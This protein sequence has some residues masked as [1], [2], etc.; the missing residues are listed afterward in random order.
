MRSSVAEAYLPPANDS[1][2]PLSV[3]E[4]FTSP[5]WTLKTGT[6]S[7]TVAAKGG[8]VVSWTVGDALDETDGRVVELLDGYYDQAELEE[9]DGGRCAL[10]VPWSNRIHDARYTF[11][12][13]VHD[14]GPDADGTREANH[15]LGLDAEFELLAE[16]DDGPCESHLTLTGV[17]GP[18][19][20]YPWTIEVTVTYSLS[21]VDGGGSALTVELEATN[22]SAVPAPVG[23][24]WHPYI[25][26][27]EDLDALTLDLPARRR[28]VTDADHIPLDGEQ[29]F[30]SVAHGDYERLA[31]AG[32]ALDD[33]WTDLVAEDDGIIRTVLSSPTGS[34]M[35]LEQRTATETPGVG[36]VQVFTGEGLVH[37]ARESVAL[38]PCQLMTDAFNRDEGV[39]EVP[40]A[41]GATRLLDAA[42]IY[43]V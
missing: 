15:G 22:L 11:A 12:G 3:A 26:L 13:V 42:L 33:A 31:L 25:R 18:E 24:G 4:R 6:C 41:P 20:G 7:L 30:R 40:L 17:V 35:T 19:P 34:T 39:Q 21:C 23:L 29:A 37:R 10:L 5:T 1:D 8:V 32:L 14:R 36:V 2:G 43:R 16:R 27:G 38:E 9:G 28:V